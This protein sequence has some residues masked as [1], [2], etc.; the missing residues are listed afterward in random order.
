MS[1]IKQD[2]GEIGGSSNFIGVLDAIYNSSL[3]PVTLTC[4]ISCNSFDVIATDIR[5]SILQNGLKVNGNVIPSAN[6]TTQWQGNGSFGGRVSV[7]F[8]LS[9]GDTISY[10][11]TAGNYGDHSAVVLFVNE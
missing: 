3:T 4:P 10:F 7:N 9:K 11:T 8:S 5:S 6:Y 1:I 2:Y